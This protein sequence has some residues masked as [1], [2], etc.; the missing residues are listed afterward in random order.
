M[1]LPTG[2][3]SPHENQVWKLKKG[4]YGLKQAGN[5]I[6]SS[7]MHWKRKALYRH[8][9]ILH[10]F[11]KSTASSFITVILYI[12]YFIIASNNMDEILIV[13]AYL[14]DVFKINDL[15]DVK[16]FLGFE[17]TRSRSGINIFQRK[18]TM[19]LLRDIGFLGCKLASIPM[20]P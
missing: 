19:A 16:F 15:G 8:I 5:G 20:V 4:L 7:L 13:K 11:L 1:K 12:H 2:F 18:Y 14:H 9:Q 6:S 3:S 17:I 10:C